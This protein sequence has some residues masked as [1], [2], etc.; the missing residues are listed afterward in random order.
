LPPQVKDEPKQEM[1]QGLP[2]GAWPNLPNRHRQQIDAAS[3]DRFVPRY[4]DLLREYYRALA[5]GGRRE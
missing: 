2:S 1:R 3:G 4:E 5:D